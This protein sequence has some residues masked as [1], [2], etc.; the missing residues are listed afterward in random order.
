MYILLI[1]FSTENEK[2]EQGNNTFKEFIV[3]FREAK[4]R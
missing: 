2:D 3:Y 1:A 4:A